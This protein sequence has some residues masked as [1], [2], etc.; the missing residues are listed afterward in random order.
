MEQGQREANGKLGPAP[1]FSDP[2][3]ILFAPDMGLNN[4][5]SFLIMNV[6]HAVK[7]ELGAITLTRHA[8]HRPVSLLCYVTEGGDLWQLPSGA[9]LH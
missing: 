2:S 3:A 8:V 1:K 4:S 6:I 9:P 7:K 5:K